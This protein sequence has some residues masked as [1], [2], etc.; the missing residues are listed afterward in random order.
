[1]FPFRPNLIKSYEGSMNTLNNIED[2]PEYTSDD[3]EKE[4]NKFQ[5][6]STSQHFTT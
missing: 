5:F 1:M 4:Q 6:H 3:I 2:I